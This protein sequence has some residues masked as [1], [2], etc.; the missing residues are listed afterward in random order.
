MAQFLF[1]FFNTDTR[2]ST[3]LEDKNKIKSASWTQSYTSRKG[4]TTV[5][6]H[7]AP[8][9]GESTKLCITHQNFPRGWAAVYLSVTIPKDATSCK[10]RATRVA[11]KCQLLCHLP[12]SSGD[13]SW[14]PSHH[15][16]KT[17]PCSTRVF[18]RGDVVFSPPDQ[19][20]SN[21]K[22]VTEIISFLE[23]EVCIYKSIKQTIYLACNSNY[24]CLAWKMDSC[25]LSTVQTS[26][27]EDCLSPRTLQS[28]WWSLMM[29]LR[30]FNY[31]PKNQVRG[32]ILNTCHKSLRKT[33][34]KSWNGI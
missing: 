21:K 26:Y 23:L 27:W 7:A 12:C 18:H 13:T 4:P 24:S 6:L 10:T 15:Y 14:L 19:E 8:G 1:F 16:T 30:Y 3:T 29:R 22:I 17:M 31:A 20:F 9:G 32:Q 2:S 11:E 34:S 33:C 5:C 28:Q 25:G